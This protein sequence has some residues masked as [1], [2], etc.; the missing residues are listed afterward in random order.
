MARLF[1]RKDSVAGAR[2]FGQ[3]DIRAVGSRPQTPAAGPAHLGMPPRSE[4]DGF[5]MPMRSMIL[6]V[7]IVASGES[8]RAASILS[9]SGETA[10]CMALPG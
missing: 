9:C 8:G 7:G 10:I 4:F 6:A 2:L 1:F 3:R 5:E